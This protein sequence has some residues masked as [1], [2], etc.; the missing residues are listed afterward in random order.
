MCS[1]SEEVAERFDYSITRQKF[2]LECLETE[3]LHFVELQ[4]NGG[5]KNFPLHRQK[6][7][8]NM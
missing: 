2:C 3:P 6:N 5:E 7:H 1:T 4:K 8:G